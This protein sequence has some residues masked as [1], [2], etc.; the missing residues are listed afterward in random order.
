[1][2]EYEVCISDNAVADLDVIYQDIYN[3]TKSA[4]ISK[5][6]M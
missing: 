6:T 1:M 5:K 3:L 4:T 2:K